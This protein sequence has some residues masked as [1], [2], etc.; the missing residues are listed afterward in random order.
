MV[1]QAHLGHPVQ[2]QAVQVQAAHVHPV[3]HINIDT[4]KESIITIII[5]TMDTII[6]YPYYCYFVDVTTTIGEQMFVYYTHI[7]YIHL[8]SNMDQ[9]TW[10]YF[11]FAIYLCN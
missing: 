5:M 8:L 11:A 1:A 9:I 2:V 7:H 4:V 3:H 6:P 10:S